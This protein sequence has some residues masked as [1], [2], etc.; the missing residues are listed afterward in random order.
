M[1]EPTQCPHCGRPV[2]S[3]RVDACLYCGAS[4]C[5]NQGEGELR[6][7]VRMDEALK[8]PPTGKGYGT[9][10]FWASLFDWGLLKYAL[11][12]LALG[13]A[14]FA[15]VLWTMRS[16]HKMS[17]RQE[18]L[19]ENALRR[20]EEAQSQA[21]QK[22]MEMRRS[23]QEAEGIGTPAT[24]ARQLALARTNLEAIKGALEAYAERN[25]HYPSSLSP[26]AYEIAWLAKT[27]YGVSSFLN[28]RITRYRC[29]PVSDTLEAFELVASANDGHQ[30]EIR[31]MGSFRLAHR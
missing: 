6:G 30:T 5:P 31:A 8:A 18:S 28:G 10:N 26:D 11:F 25:G 24:S 2:L 23:V 4:L 7:V 13:T 16:V 17:E 20:S 29:Y 1:P 19:A 15:A 12:G 21:F 27:P 9:R 3:K 22:Q 14:I